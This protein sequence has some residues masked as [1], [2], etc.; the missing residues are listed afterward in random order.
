MIIED[1]NDVKREKKDKK[2]KKD[3]KEKKEKK[4]K[5]NKESKKEKKHKKTEKRKA[6]IA[7]GSSVESSTITSSA[8]ASVTLSTP[9][10]KLKPSS[11]VAM[12]AS[13]SSTS[14]E[15]TLLLFYQYVEPP[16]SVSRHK[17]ALHHIQTSGLKHGLGGRMRC[18]RE[19]LNCT[20]TGPDA[21]VRAWC[22]ELR[23]FDPAFEGTEFKLTPGLPP[24]QHFPKL[25]AFPV[26]ELV[27]YGLAGSRAPPISRTAA[28]LEPAEY[29]S[30]MSEP[31]TVI[32]DVRNHYEAMIGHFSPPPGG[33]EMLDPKMRKSTEF[34]AWL[35]RDSTKEKIR[36]KQV[37]MYCTGGVRCERASALLRSKLE[38]T[39]NALGV[40]GV[41]Q[42]QGGIH[43]YIEQ[44]PDG[45]NW[46]GKNYTFDKRFAHAPLKL[47]GEGKVA[48]VGR[49]EKC[50]AE[51][52]RFRGKRR[53]PMCG[54]PS[55]IC[56]GCWDKHESGEEIIGD[57]VKCELCK[58]EGIMS[59]K[60]WRQKEDRIIG[61]YEEKVRGDAGPELNLKAP[62]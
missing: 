20:I 50:D 51:W 43:K 60:E 3:K 40:K 9:K 57:D 39:D 54:V 36:G 5:K 17:A 1:D 62:K 35:D 12:P 6:E 18:A 7:N 24:G 47:E 25:N 55:L 11:S 32:I 44:H 38:E 23:A 13:N 41:Y 4:E 29:H 42:L 28:H 19:G 45:G 26:E 52:D 53:C 21:G 14:S 2:D 10:K 15:V 37:L 33:A 46:R 49:C 16:W 30:K 22:D 59:K 48:V 27:N 56:K 61:D 58:E 8:A 34:P 31:D